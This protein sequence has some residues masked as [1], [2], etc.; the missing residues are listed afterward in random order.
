MPRLSDVNK[1]CMT[2]LGAIRTS[3]LYRDIKAS[4][5]LFSKNHAF[6]RE[7]IY[8]LKHFWLRKDDEFDNLLN[9]LNAI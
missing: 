7:I 4:V 5:K 3:M 2:L 9:E 6:L 8:D 1:S